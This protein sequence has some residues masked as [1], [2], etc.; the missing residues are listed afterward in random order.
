MAIKQLNIL[1]HC[2]TKHLSGSILGLFLYCLLHHLELFNKG[3]SL[4]HQTNV[5]LLRIGGLADFG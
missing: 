4:A 1:D 2:H 5:D 3:R